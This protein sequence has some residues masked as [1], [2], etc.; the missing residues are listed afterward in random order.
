MPLVTIDLLEGHSPQELDT[1]IYQLDQSLF[2]TSAASGSS[3]P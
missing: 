2:P 3:G 1:I